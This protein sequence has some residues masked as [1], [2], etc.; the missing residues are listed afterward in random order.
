VGAGG[1]EREGAHGGAHGGA[2]AG[3][4]RVGER[5]ASGGASRACASA[6]LRRS[7]HCVSHSLLLKHALLVCDDKEVDR[8]HTQHEEHAGACSDGA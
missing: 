5:A 1:G 2:S 3:G 8:H 4:E 7:R 6:A